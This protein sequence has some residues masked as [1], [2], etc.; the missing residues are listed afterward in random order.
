MPIEFARRDSLGKPMVSKKKQAFLSAFESCGSRHGGSQAARI[1][2]EAH[3]LWLRTGREGFRS[4]LIAHSEV[5]TGA[6]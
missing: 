3:Y 5:S 1:S 4:R 6:Y 2:R